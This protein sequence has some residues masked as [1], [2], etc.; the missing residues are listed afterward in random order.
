LVVCAAAA[1]RAGFF[2]Y[3][4]PLF[5]KLFDFATNEIFHV[6]ETVSGGGDCLV[7]M[8]TAPDLEGR[9]GLYYNNGIEASEPTVGRCKMSA[10]KV[11]T[12][13]PPT[14]HIPATHCAATCN[15]QCICIQLSVCAFFR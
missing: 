11:S 15:G 6:A 5:V 12:R 10:T 8:V 9:G 3:Q 14:F 4:N 7:Y 2:R 1:L 13:D